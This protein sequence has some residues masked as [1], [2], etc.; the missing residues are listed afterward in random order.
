MR[1]SEKKAS[2]YK[3]RAVLLKKNLKKRKEF[4]I[5]TNK[6]NYDSSLR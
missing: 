3:S 6:K 2:H 4:K 1:P 5:K